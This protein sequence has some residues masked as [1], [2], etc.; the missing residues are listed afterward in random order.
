MSNSFEIPDK[1]KMM[2]LFLDLA[3]YDS[4]SFHERRVADR[5]RTELQ[6]LGFEVTEDDAVA[7]CGGESGNLYGFLKGTTNQEPVFFFRT[8]GYGETRTGEETA[9]Q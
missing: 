2:T 7:H 9:D 4:L 5:L 6:A 3:Q 8:Y 1:E